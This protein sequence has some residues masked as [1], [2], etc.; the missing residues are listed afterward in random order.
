MRIGWTESFKTLLFPKFS[1]SILWIIGT[2]MSCQIREILLTGH[3]M[4]CFVYMYIFVCLVW[5]FFRFWHA[6]GSSFFTH[7]FDYPHDIFDP[8]FVLVFLFIFCRIYISRFFSPCYRQWPNC[9]KKSI[10]SLDFKY[11]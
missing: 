5:C 11:K 4:M 9:S 2:M 10:R 3:S 6:M 8:F 7:M 1:A